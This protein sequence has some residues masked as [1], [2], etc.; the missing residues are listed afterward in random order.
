L[1]AAHTFAAAYAAGYSC[2]IADWR[3]P[4]LEASRFWPR[5]GFR[6][7]FYRLARRI[8]ERVIWAR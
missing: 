2:G 6:A 8:E 7:A 3:V 4:N 1:F 5:Q